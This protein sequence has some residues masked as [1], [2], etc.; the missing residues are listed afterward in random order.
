MVAFYNEEDQNIYKTNQFMPQSRFLLNPYT[1]PAASEPVAPV[2]GGITN[3]NA[4][5][6]GGSD[7]SVYNPDPNSIVNRNYDALRYREAT[8]ENY[9]RPEPT[10]ANKFLGSLTN[11]IPG[12]GIGEFLTSY[13]P[14]N[15]RKIL[16][17]ELGVEGIMVNDIG[18]I[19]QGGGDYNTADNIMAGY[20]ASKIDANTYQKRRD[21]INDTIKRKTKAAELKGEVYDS[22][23]LDNRLD[24]LDASEET[25][26]DTATGR[27]D[28]IVDFEEEE[29]EKKKNK[30]KSFLS[31]IFR[32]K[33]KTQ[34]A[35][36]N[37]D[38]KT[39][40]G[41]DKTSVTRT[42]AGSGFNYDTDTTGQAKTSPGGTYTATVTPQESLENIDKARMNR[43]TG[44]RAGYF[45]GGRA[46]L[47]GGGMSQGNEENIKQST[48]MGGGITGDLSTSK[49][50]ENNDRSIR[51]N[52]K[53]KPS[54][55]ENMVN[56]GSEVNYLKNLYK[57]DPVGLGIGFG[58]NKLRTYIK[59][60]N[61][62][63]EDTL[64]YNTNSL[65]TNNYTAKLVGPALAQMRTLEKAKGMEQFG[66]S[67][68]TEQ[69]QGLNKLKQMDQEKTIYSQP[70]FVGANGGRAMFKNGGLASIL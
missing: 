4:F 66:G 51:E 64:S 33:K 41:D 35:K 20:N 11:L 39:T 21:M 49:Q 42:T 52:Q 45:F 30:T 28:E 63:E 47:Q 32:R 46:R 10:G 62:P 18:Q 43:A 6:N 55:L 70:I 56:L 59:N 61:L 69:E 8:D 31:N 53:T 24:A 34:V 13:M 37:Q 19:V 22:E 26:L 17:N 65:P 27:A 60:K 7:F 15:R 3:T 50:T 1:P 68:S 5:N 36:K 54:G 9:T 44:G 16:E 40:D 2:Q 14:P 25:V 38:N 48:D 12:K 58:I 57:M 23:Y 67:F 29:K